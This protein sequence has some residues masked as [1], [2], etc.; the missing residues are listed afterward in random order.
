MLTIKPNDAVFIMKLH[1]PNCL[2]SAAQMQHAAALITKLSFYFKM[3]KDM[4][5]GICTKQTQYVAVSEF[6]GWV[7]MRKGLF[8]PDTFGLV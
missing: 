5:Y 4:F 2:I 7:L 6:T 8:T 3:Q 1:Q